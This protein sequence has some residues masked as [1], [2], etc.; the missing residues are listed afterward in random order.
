M[1][2]IPKI[3]FDALLKTI[4]SYWKTGDR[5]LLEIKTVLAEKLQMETGVDWLA[6][7]SFADSIFQYRGLNPNTSYKT[8]YE[9]LKVLGYEV[10]AD[11]EVQESE[12]V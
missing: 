6:F 7:C 12:S 11:A 3:T 5:E 9:A 1:K 8:I 4:K 10:V 2:K